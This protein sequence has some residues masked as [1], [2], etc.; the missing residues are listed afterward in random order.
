MQYLM[1]FNEFNIQLKNFYNHY[2]YY[3]KK[4]NDE[5]IMSYIPYNEMILSPNLVTKNII[6]IIFF[7]YSFVVTMLLFYFTNIYENIKYFFYSNK[8]N[9]NN[10]NYRKKL[11]LS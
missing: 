9:K 4:I 6:C 7:F 5:A 1:D 10:Y 11:I 3:L 8:R 2:D